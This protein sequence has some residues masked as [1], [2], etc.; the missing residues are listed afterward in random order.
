[1]AVVL[2]MAGLATFAVLRLV[3]LSGGFD[4]T[5]Q[6]VS[7]ARTLP[8]PGHRQGDARSDISLRATAD[9][10]DAGTDQGV[11]ESLLQTISAAKDNAG[12]AQGDLAAVFESIEEGSV[13]FINGLERLIP[14]IDQYHRLVDELMDESAGSIV[15]NLTF[16]RTSLAQE[17]KAAS[18]ELPAKSSTL[19]FS[20]ETPPRAPP[21]SVRK[22]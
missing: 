22:T 21:I 20:A 18:S 17:G 1:M 13:T 12:G 4:Q 5:V 10:P 7:E 19:S 2:V 3:S 16:L 8:S 14:L 9:G 6:M 11:D 15:V